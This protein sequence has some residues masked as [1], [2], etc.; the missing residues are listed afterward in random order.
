MKSS[1]VVGALQGADRSRQ[2]A[3]P[4]I[5][6]CAMLG[7]RLW[8]SVCLALYLAFWLE[9]PSPG[10]AGT[11]AA[12]VCQPHLGASLRKGWFRLIGTSV[13]AVAIV[14]LTVAFPQDR[15]PY[16]I[17][18]ALWA[19]ACAFAATLLRNFASYAAALAGY[20]AAVIA[21]DVLGATGGP[22]AQVFDFA[23][24][25]TS[26]IAL[27]IVCAGVVLAG[28]EFG[29]ARQVLAAR[30]TTLTAVIARRFTDTLVPDG[31]GSRETQAMR[32]E[33]ARQ[34]TALDPVIDDAI[35]EAPTLRY[36]SAVLG[37]L[38]HALFSTLAC[39][40]T[41]G[42][43]LARMPE[44]EGRQ[45]AEAVLL[46]IP[47]ELR[48]VLQAGVPAPWQDRPARLLRHC[49]ET[50][51][52]LL[53]LPA[54]TPSRRLVL[55]R[56][57]EFLGGISQVL[58]ALALL[59]DDPDRPPDSRRSAWPSVP[60]WLP[61]MLN[62]GRA[63]LAIA[64]LEMFWILSAWPNGA[65]A[66]VW[67]M[68]AVTLF[69]PMAERAYSDTVTYITGTGLVAIPAGVTVFLLLPRM[70]TFAGF[71]LTIGL[72]LVPFGALTAQPWRAPV[73]AAMAAGF[74]PMIAPTNVMTYDAAGF[75]NNA[76]TIVF[77]GAFGALWF[78]LLPPM[79][80]A[81]RAQRLLALTLRDFRR[82]AAD[83]GRWTVE[84]W[85]R[86]IQA[87]MAVLP[88]AA[89]AVQRGQ[90]LAAMALGGALARLR[91]LV[92]EL[93]PAQG[94]EALA[95]ALARGDVGAATAR[96]ATLDQGLSVGAAGDAGHDALLR[97]RSCILTIG[98]ALA[99][100]PAYFGQ[101]VTR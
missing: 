37:S 38:T 83:G 84:D 67:A 65:A 53:R 94:A 100:H 29:G 72:F 39:W 101:A 56:T 10:W 40:R 27:G 4:S 46:A 66:I 57:A 12:L 1:S 17:G 45:E 71:A 55:D 61:P 13:G 92:R 85:D 47:A 50:R 26:E 6:S 8:A 76:L 80:P 69:G 63:L 14:L 24:A 34:V 68:V 32:R 9:L 88:D 23:V 35:G 89:E 64:V 90:L 25:R 77:G 79:P 52:R 97:A 74:I 19:A 96:L 48:C 98:E 28:T 7:L 41:L 5:L 36:H 95:G 58:A 59:Q 73:F 43:H 44:A 60:N 93:G 91:D 30:I 31:P 11:T 3:W 20:T 18:L 75:F 70:E 15:G 99:D 54:D 42:T 21:S 62:A 81:R 51:R 82:F 87:R 78:L 2:G 33:L 49:V 86:R 22:D 16:L